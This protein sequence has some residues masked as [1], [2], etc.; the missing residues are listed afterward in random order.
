[1]ILRRLAEILWPLP[2]PPLVL[3][4]TTEGVISFGGG[5]KDVFQSAPLG[6][7]ALLYILVYA[8][9]WSR[10][11]RVGRALGISVMVTA[12]ILMLVWLA[13][14]GLSLSGMV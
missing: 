7:F 3:F 12:G 2:V 14:L 4:L 5:E 9:C 10:R 6:I 8:V 1:M 11:V 13:L